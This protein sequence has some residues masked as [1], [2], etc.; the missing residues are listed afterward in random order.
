MLSGV[1]RRAHAALRAAMCVCISGALSTVATA[2]VPPPPT[3]GESSFSIFLRATPSGFERSSVSRTEDG[4]L[5]R[6]SNQMTAPIALETRLFEMAYN[7]EWQPQRLSM[8]GT[9]DGDLFSIESIFRGDI[10]TNEVRIGTAVSTSEERIDATSVVLPN[11]FFAAY[12][13]LAVRLS[14][15]EPGAQIPVYVA[16]RGYITARVISVDTQRLETAA[17]AL[18]AQIFQVTFDNPN[19]PIDAEIWVDEGRRLMRV[20]LPSASIDVARQDIISVSTRLTSAPHPGDE[21]VR[22]AAAGFSLAATVTTPVDVAPPN[23]GQW[24]AVLL[25]PGSDSVDR[26]ATVFGVSIFRQLART[27]VSNGF[28]VMRYDKRGT[29]Q[30]GGRA[31]SATLDDYAEDARELVRYLERR[32]D[33]D[34]DRVVVVGYSEGGWI[35]LLAARRERKI[36]AL[37]LIAASGIS[38]NRLILEQQQ[39]ALDETDESDAQ[40]QE[41]VELQQRIHRAVLEEGDWEGIQP[42]VRR[43]ADT[44][45]FRSLLTFDPADAVRR[46]RQPLLIIQGELDQQIL[47]YHADRLESLAQARTREESTVEVA[48]LD[49]VNHLLVPATT[50]SISEYASLPDRQITPRVAETIVDWIG[51]TLP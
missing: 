43:Q 1:Q 23:S 28:M 44:P 20:R 9:Q 22:V 2:Q 32:D 39:T 19:E 30:S 24:P 34:R 40:Q 48:K 8:A 50:G 21:N 41:K 14:V 25:V 16:P 27:L 49:G 5:I 37:A 4:W 33:V 18:T 15:S 46:V 31:E 47:S 38:G 36:K 13:A 17:G 29:G 6:A 45:W 51:R 3:V 35:G 12:E 11:F 7:A 42:A 10:V 26:D